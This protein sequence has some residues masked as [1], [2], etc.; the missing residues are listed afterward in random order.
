MK[1]IDPRKTADG[2]SKAGAFAVHHN[3]ITGMGA[4]QRGPGVAEADQNQ[5]M[6]KS[7]LNFF[8][9]SQQRNNFDDISDKSKPIK[10]G[11]FI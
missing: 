8:N 1:T 7:A 9:P 5:G 4:P 6:T 10:D 11:D 2:F 3:P